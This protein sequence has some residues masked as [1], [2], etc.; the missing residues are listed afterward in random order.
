MTL[1]DEYGSNGIGTWRAQATQG[2]SPGRPGP[3]M[4]YESPEKGV[5]MA[6]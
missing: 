5:V 2:D 6:D 1:R 3:W 4:K